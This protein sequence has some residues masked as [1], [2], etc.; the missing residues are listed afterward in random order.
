LNI[1]LVVSGS[2]SLEIT[3]KVKE[4]LTGRKKVFRV[5]PLSFCEIVK[6]KGQIPAGLFP[7][8]TD[9]K[10]IIEHQR[11]FGEYLLSELKDFITY[12]GYPKVYLRKEPEKKEAELSEIFSSYVKKDV[13]DYL[14]IERVDVFNRLVS[15][16]AFQIGNLVNKQE[17][18]VSLQTAWVTI[19]KYLK[20]LDETFV[21]RLLPP[22]YTNRRKEITKMQ[23]VYYMDTG[24]RN[25]IVRNF[26]G[27]NAR[28][29]KGVL[30]ENIFFTERIKQLKEPSSLGFWRTQ[31][32]AEV[33]FVLIDGEKITPVEVKAT[34]LNRPKLTK[35]F[36]N[37]IDAH[38]PE[39][40]IVTT[41][42]FCSEIT[43]GKTAVKFIP[44]PWMVLG[45]AQK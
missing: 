9:V 4:Y 8:K 26:T 1:K 41:I 37:F 28:A 34:R 14:K 27:L 23:K 12:G 16:L 29:D 10:K 19:E 20:V 18:S 15:L 39:D 11:L 40:A 44:L 38:K 7:E 31:A 13:K 6:H 21:I 5:Y 36:K 17:L 43:Y 35:S 32:G 30:F 45:F 2:S 33:D 42:D 25:F 3:A 24:L 22:Y